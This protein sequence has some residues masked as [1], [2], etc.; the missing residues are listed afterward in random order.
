[1]KQRLLKFPAVALLLFLNVGLI[2][3]GSD[4]LDVDVSAISV[5][6]VRVE[7]YDSAL[8]AVDTSKIPQQLDALQ[9][10]FGDFSPGFIN[11][12]V[13]RSGRDSILRDLDIRNFLNDY[14][15]RGVYNDY[16]KIYTGDFSW[17]EKDITAAYKHFKYYF[18]KREL[19]KGV[20]TDMTGFNYN[21]LQIEGYY[22]I[23]LEYYL[24]SSSVYYDQL[25]WPAYKRYT[26]RKEYMASNFVRAWMMTEFPYQPPK[27]DLINRMVYEGKLLYLQ[28]ALLRET[29]DTIILG[30]SQKQL[31]WSLD[32]EFKMWSSLIENQKLYSEDEEDLQHYTEEAPFT[33]DFPR[34]SPGKA[35]NWLGLRIVEAFMKNNPKVTLE[36][37]MQNQDGAAILNRSKYKPKP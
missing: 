6:Q 7:R 26:C 19:P 15:T 16:S 25:Q 5:P 29:P 36:Q 13:C 28:K 20:Y 12:I 34:E 8:F 4:P 31:Q 21:I 32:N 23:G 2:S 37:L 9:K 27:N 18:P 1:M 14:S 11:N 30:Y 17:L 10:K 22:G 24:G 3:C 33:P 35:G